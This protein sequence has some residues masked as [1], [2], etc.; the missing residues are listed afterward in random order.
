MQVDLVIT[1]SLAIAMSALLAMGALHK[2]SDLRGF[3]GVIR[4]YRLLPAQMSVPLG[5]SLIGAEAV[6]D[7]SGGTRRARPG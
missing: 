7:G 1:L 2:L 4:D 6:T 3:F 5:V